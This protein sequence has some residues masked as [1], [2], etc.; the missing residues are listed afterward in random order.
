M[1]KPAKTIRV[2]REYTIHINT[3]K[4]ITEDLFHTMKMKFTRQDDK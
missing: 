3:N 2:M 4:E 1:T